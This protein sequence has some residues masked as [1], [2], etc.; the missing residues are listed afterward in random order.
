MKDLSDT[1]APLMCSYPNPHRLHVPHTHDFFCLPPRYYAKP[2]LHGHIGVV[3]KVLEAI[4]I[5]A[6]VVDELWFTFRYPGGSEKKD[7]DEKLAR[8]HL[9][10]ALS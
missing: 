10:Q 1:N 6:R 8:R 7:L 9:S 4:D 5:A 3:N 2:S